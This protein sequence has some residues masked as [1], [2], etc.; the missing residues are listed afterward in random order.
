MPEVH[1]YSKRSRKS[2]LA[3]PYFLHVLVCLA[4]GWIDSAGAAAPPAVGLAVP[5]LA[6]F[7]TVMKEMMRTNNVTAGELG[8]MRYGVVVFHR[9]YGWQ[10]QALTR[11]L[12]PDALMRVGSVSK[13]F[14][15]AAVRKLI[16]E[17]RLSLQDRV[18]SLGRAGTG[19][20]PH[21]PFLKPGAVLD[22]R[23]ANI[24]VQHCL[25]HTGGWD[26]D[27]VG[28]PMFR[29][30]QAAAELGVTSP[31]HT[32]EMLRW[33]LGQ[34]L[35]HNPGTTYAYANLGYMVLGLVIEKVSGQPYLACL[36]ERVTRPIGILDS[37]LKS[38]EALL[39]DQ[40]P[41]E[42]YYAT[43]G[44]VDNLFY[45]AYSHLPKVERP[46]GSFGMEHRKASGGLITNVRQLLLLAEH[47]TVF[48]NNVG[49][50]WTRRG[51]VAKS[52]GLPGTSAFISQRSDGINI[53]VICNRSGVAPDIAAAI[54]GLIT[55]GKIAKWPAVDPYALPPTAP[56]LQISPAPANLR[57]ATE[58][59][60]YYQILRATA[61]FQWE[62]WSPPFV[63]DGTDRT[64][65]VGSGGPGPSF[66][67]PP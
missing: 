62:P 21:V 24:T 12:A 47:F 5:A 13:S 46:Y 4:L 1:S 65:S 23:L 55:S 28:D 25:Q 51:T 20:L 16:S 56:I 45:P 34:P 9:S 6:I 14:T 7:D 10:D 22:E 2:I 18:F 15:A 57:M 44:L 33:I 35:Q 31:P 39:V 3:W 60:R 36:R 54:V 64:F 42:P 43:S 38:G 48:G 66:S 40:D 32:D 50:P 59:D 58:P 11:L 63:G 61:L 26:S 19:I 37:E 27:L 8:V 30:D 29:E 17:G 41:R 53:A 67:R 49:T 52:G